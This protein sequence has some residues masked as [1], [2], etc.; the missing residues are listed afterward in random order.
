MIASRGD[1]WGLFQPYAHLSS[2]RIASGTLVLSPRFEAL[3]EQQQQQSNNKA[4][5]KER[6]VRQILLTTCVGSTEELEEM[7]LIAGGICQ[8]AWNIQQQQ[9]GGGATPSSP[10]PPFSSTTSSSSSSNNTSSSLRSSS[11]SSSSSPP[12]PPRWGPGS[13]PALYHFMRCSQLEYVGQSEG[14]TP[15][16]E[17]VYERP[18][19]VLPPVAEW[20][21]CAL[22]F[23][24]HRG[25]GAVD[26]DDVSQAARVLLPG[27]DCPP[28]PVL[29][30]QLF[31]PFFSASL[32]TNT[33]LPSDS[34]SSEQPLVD[35]MRRNLAYQM[36]L[37]GRRDLVPHAMQLMSP[38]SPSPALMMNQLP[39]SLQRSSSSPS[40]SST[41]MSNSSG[42]TPLHVAAAKGN[43]SVLRMLLETGACG[44][45]DAVAGEGAD[46]DLRHWTPLTYAAITGQVKVKT[47]V[48]LRGEKIPTTNCCYCSCG[49]IYIV[50]AA[51]VIVPTI[52]IFYYFCF[53]N[54]SSFY[55]FSCCCCC[56]CC[57]QLL[58]MPL[59]FFFRW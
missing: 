33:T 56:C 59:M 39:S 23:A 20:V 11:T 10:P 17:L 47:R 5:N 2:S 49:F 43:L 19:L 7:V 29:D 44:D 24:L 12:L 15:I 3:L 38:S 37:T 9:Q 48:Y 51:A 21:R 1:L 8:K 16:Q 53:I 40:S 25:A 13:V 31:N 6:S 58:L 45:V 36:L 35:A 42:L 26:A 50:V 55:S 4:G 46:E 30:E 52:I 57:K 14:R 27:C 41:A 32:P 54:R 18:Y 22:A 28:R 34:S